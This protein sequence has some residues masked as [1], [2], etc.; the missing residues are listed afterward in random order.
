MSRHVLVTGGAGFIGSHLVGALHQQ[1]HRV[2]VLDVFDSQVHATAEPRFASEIAECIVGDV[3]DPETVRRCLRDVD[4][5]VHLAAAVGVGQSM[6]KVRYYTDT[7]CGGTAVLWEGIL[8]ARERVEKV[9]VASSMSIYGEGDP[10]KTAE[11]HPLRPTSVYA[12]TKRDQEEISLCLGRAYGIPTVALRFFNVYG[13]E[14]SL[15]NPYTGVAAI[16]ISQL[17]NGEAPVIFGDG[18]QTRDF[19]HVSDIVQAIGLAL[20]A[21]CPSDA[22]NVGTGVQTSILELAHLLARELSFTGPIGPSGQVRAG[23]II[24]CVGDITKITGALGYRP[25]VA[26]AEGVGDLIDW[27]RQQGATD[28]VAAAVDEL[29]TRGLLE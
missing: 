20:Q 3:R 19:T 12:V 24:H 13:P 7:N 15:D 18:N 10:E 9:V 8:A 14:Q 17:L 26:L 5:V 6:Y 1:G 23:D 11:T 25:R 21:D 29:A 22:Y 27:A 2:R 16:F 4:S 28:S